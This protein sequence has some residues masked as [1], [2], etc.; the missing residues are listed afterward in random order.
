MVECDE[1][2][3]VA[4]SVSFM[5]FVKIVEMVCDV[6]N[7]PYAE[8]LARIAEKLMNCMKEVGD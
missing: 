3:Q 1:F 7:K 5:E 8:V 4:K 2:V 6:I